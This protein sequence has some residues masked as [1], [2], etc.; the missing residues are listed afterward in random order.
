MQPLLIFQLLDEIR[1]KLDA[2]Q[3]N[4]KER[5]TSRELKIAQEN[6]ETSHVVTTPRGTHLDP[7]WEGDLPDTTEDAP[8]TLNPRAHLAPGAGD[9]HTG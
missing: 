6:E 2:I 9:L 1:S 4:D 8:V 3:Q 7:T 5:Q